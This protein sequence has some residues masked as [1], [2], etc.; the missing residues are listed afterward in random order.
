[1]RAEAVWQNVAFTQAIR[2]RNFGITWHR[3]TKCWCYCLALSITKDEESADSGSGIHDRCARLCSADEIASQVDAI[4]SDI[5]HH[6]VGV[7]LSKLYVTQPSHKSANN[8]PI[9]LLIR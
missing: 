4:Y 1:M 5:R 8:M 9:A 7:T 3:A 6:K 2:L